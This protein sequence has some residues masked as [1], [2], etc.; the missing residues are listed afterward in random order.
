[1]LSYARLE[2]RRRREV[3]INEVT[4]E[5]YEELRPEMDAHGVRLSF[6]PDAAVGACWIDPVGLYDAIANLVV[7]AREALADETEGIIEIRTQAI[8]A[9]SI[10]VAVSDNGVGIPPDQLERVFL[11]FYTTK[12]HGTGMG[13]AMVRRFVAEMGGTIHLDSQPGGGT[14]VKIT[15]PLTLADD[16][17]EPS[18]TTGQPG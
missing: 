16:E 2:D 13:L 7:N 8:G 9:E 5:V 17:E 10:L 14:T 4:R 1:M 18:K 11:P 15:F 6:H 3:R 12:D